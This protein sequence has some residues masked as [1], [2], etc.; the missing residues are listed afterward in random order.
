VKRPNRANAP[1]FSRWVLIIT[2]GVCAAAAAQSQGGGR[3]VQIQPGVL[4]DPVDDRAFLMTPAGAIEAID[5]ASG[6]SLWVTEAAEKPVTVTPGRL[7][8]HSSGESPGILPLA[9]IDPTD[10]RV[11]LTREARLPDAVRVSVDQGLSSSFELES[12]EGPGPVRM[13][14]RFH[15]GTAQG[16]PTESVDPGISLSG[17]LS[18][19]SRSGSLETLADRAP[20]R[21][22]A[23]VELPSP[24][25]SRLRNFR[26]VDDRFVLVSTAAAPVGH[27]LQYDWQIEDRSGGVLGHTRTNL[28]YSPFTVSGNTL[29]YTT[30]PQNAFVDGQETIQ[31]L[32]LRAVDL[33][34]GEERWSREIRDIRYMGPFPM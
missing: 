17:E 10:G 29:L 26:S 7:V 5:I 8:A 28:S 4:V 12:A 24:D 13:H 32:T 22:A 27:D 19:D 15:A 34:S 14:W 31:G 1:V 21:A 9:V 33:E 6:D 25:R 23:N 18:F 30:P 3:S 2:L 20:P 11:M 16:V